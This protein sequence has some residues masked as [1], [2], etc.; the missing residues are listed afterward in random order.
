ML[1]QPMHA[2]L[3]PRA[4]G[5][6]HKVGNV[7]LLSLV[8]HVVM[9]VNMENVRWWDIVCLP[10]LPPTGEGLIVPFHNHRHGTAGPVKQLL[11]TQDGVRN[12]IEVV[13]VDIKDRVHH[14]QFT[15][16]RLH[17]LGHCSQFLL[18][19][20]HLD[21]CLQ[22]LLDV[23]KDLGCFLIAHEIQAEMARH[24][25]ESKRHLWHTEEL[26]GDFPGC[27]VARQGCVGGTLEIGLGASDTSE[28]IRQ[29][30]VGMR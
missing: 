26:S 30:N 27:N 19:L 12:L 6:E 22:I 16:E 8:H 11:Q 13:K 5:V 20:G 4:H 29:R 9:F 28:W 24:V 14:F 25:A 2:A 18:V 21:K 7:G 17:R 15:T 23:V 10:S 3:R 1:D